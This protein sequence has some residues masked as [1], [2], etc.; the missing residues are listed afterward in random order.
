M[1]ISSRSRW[2]SC[3]HRA[4]QLQTVAKELSILW[5]HMELLSVRRGVLGVISGGEDADEK[6]RILKETAL[7]DSFLS[8]A[9]Q[10]N[11]E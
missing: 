1:Q 2:A 7:V 5:D 3:A 8:R 11:A 9:L 4:Y 10:E 6:T